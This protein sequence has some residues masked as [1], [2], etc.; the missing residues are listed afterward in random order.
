M[1]LNFDLTKM[2][3]VPSKCV[4]PECDQLTRTYFNDFDLESP[5]EVCAHDGVFELPV[6]CEHCGA[7]FVLAFKTVPQFKTL[8]T[9]TK[10][11]DY[12]EY[13]DTTT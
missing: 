6:N 3:G 2:L 11:D 10:T 1:G 13:H 4:C 5:P 12:A 8:P 9:K 7:P